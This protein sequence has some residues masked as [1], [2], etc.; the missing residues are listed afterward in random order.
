MHDVLLHS[1]S[2]VRYVE[3]GEARKMYAGV[4]A[5]LVGVIVGG[6]LSL[7]L[8]VWERRTRKADECHSQ[9]L[10]LVREIMRYRLDQQHLVESLN[11]LPLM[12]GDDADVLRLYRETL[13]AQDP[14]ARTRALTDLINRLAASVGMPVAV[15]VSD[16]RCGFTVSRR[17]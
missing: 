1:V 3:L 16:V 9:R 17:D 15:Q 7:L 5:S 8:S 11:E 14:E 2:S 13:G 4:V 12:F 10:A 6:L